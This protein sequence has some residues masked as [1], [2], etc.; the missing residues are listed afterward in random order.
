[1]RL[2]KYLSQNNICSRREAEYFINQGWLKVD[3]QVVREQGTQVTESSVVVLN[4]QA[5]DYQNRLVTILL[6]KPIGYVSGQPEQGNKP[7]VKL[8]RKKNCQGNPNQNGDIKVKWP[9]TGLA[10]AGRL[11]SDSTGFLVFTQDGRIARK[12]IGP[13]SEIEKEYLV[14]TDSQISSRQQSTLSG[15]LSLDGKKLKPA[16]IE[17]IDKKF[18]KFTLTEGR[19]RQIRRMCDLVGLSV[20]SLKRVRIG[21]IVLGALPVGKWRYLTEGEQF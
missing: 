7:A 9:L 10:P 8:I 11:D 13:D 17:V 16:K 1:M 21:G 20:V 18:F 5:K 19:N 3:G 12:L 15:G 4:P 6:H 2:S 14:R